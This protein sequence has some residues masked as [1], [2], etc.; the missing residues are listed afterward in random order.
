MRYLISFVAVAAVLAGSYFTGV[1][2][3][4]NRMAS[5]ISLMEQVNSFNMES[6]DELEASCVSLRKAVEV[7]E[8]ALDKVRK[9]ERK[10][11]QDEA[12][13]LRR[14]LDEVRKAYD[15]V[16]EWA[17]DIVPDDIVDR[18]LAEADSY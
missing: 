15:K 9:A 12:E 17:H 10:A 5:K 2:Q 16:P 18:L 11:A 3:T 4:S 7:T 13:R 1:W 6:L 8:E 14:E